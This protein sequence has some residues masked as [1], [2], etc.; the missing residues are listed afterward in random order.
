MPYVDNII[1]YQRMGTHTDLCA[2][3][4]VVT[5]SFKEYIRTAPR[6]AT[7]LEKEF[8]LFKLL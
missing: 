4:I 1:D 3:I 7:Y 8:D 5:K 6:L 2:M